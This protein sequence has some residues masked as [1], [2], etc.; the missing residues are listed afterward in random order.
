MKILLD[1]CIDHRFR[2]ELSEYDVKTV[3]FM[4]WDS[5]Q[6]GALLR[7]AETEFDIFITVDANICFQQNFSNVSLAVIILRPV[8]NR[9]LFL[10]DMVPQIKKVI[11]TIKSGNVETIFPAEPA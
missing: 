2:F 3:S 10:K 8:R 6:N 11:S 9:L 5:L 1:E 4:G 7:R